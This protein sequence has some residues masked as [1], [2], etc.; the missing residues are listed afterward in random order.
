[1]KTSL[2]RPGMWS[3]S[4][5]SACLLSFVSCAAHRD[6]ALT[7]AVIAWAERNGM[8]IDHWQAGQ[9]PDEHFNRQAWKGEGQA[10]PGAEEI[11][12]GLLKTH[13]KRLEPV[14]AVRALGAVGSAASVPTLEEQT[15]SD[16]DVMRTI[17]VCALAE[18]GD[19]R[20]LSAIAVCLLYDESQSCRRAAARS[21]AV[22][23]DP[24][25]VESLEEALKSLREE[26]SIVE[27]ALKDLRA[28]TE[29]DAT[30]GQQ[31]EK[32]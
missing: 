17:A 15:K 22:L 12:L 5:C 32:A 25:G 28:R 4:L 21:I 31:K 19:P 11:L 8:R 29:S 27:Q 9:L 13:D 7:Q 1:M 30:G 20:G 2:T 10:L 26:E 18:I 23:G 24:R 14:L 16:W 3:C 6:D